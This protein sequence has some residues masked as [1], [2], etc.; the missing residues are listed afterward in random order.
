MHFNGRHLF[1]LFAGHFVMF[2]VQSLC[3]ITR[4]LGERWLFSRHQWKNICQGAV[5]NMKDLP[6]RSL[7]TILLLFLGDLM[8]W[9][10]F[11][12]G[13]HMALHQ[14][15][16]GVRHHVIKFVCMQWGVT[17]NVFHIAL[18]LFMM[19][20]GCIEILICGY[21]RLLVLFC[22]VGSIVWTLNGIPNPFWAAWN[23][24]CKDV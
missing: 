14:E 2:C 13:H 21:S 17:G 20:T 9:L 1:L 18:L 19:L 3:Y 4:R 11:P 15:R 24:D 12:R 22:S 10:V 6:P 7:Q 16:F 8:F 5:P 23:W